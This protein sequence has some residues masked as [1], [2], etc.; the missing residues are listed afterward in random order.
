M[1]PGAS[2]NFCHV[3][4]LL[5]LNAALP[6][7]AALFNDPAELPFHKTYDYIVVGGMYLH[8]SS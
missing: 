1:L 6:A 7:F 8:Q 2:L 5:L 4:S 3:V